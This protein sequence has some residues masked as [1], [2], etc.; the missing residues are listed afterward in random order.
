MPRKPKAVSRV[1]TFFGV[2][3]LEPTHLDF[4]KL[5]EQKNK[6]QAN[7]TIQWKDV[8]FGDQV[9]LIRE[10][11]TPKHSLIHPN[12]GYMKYWDIIIVCALVFTALVT[13][14][15]VAYLETKL[16]GLFVINRFIDVI[17]VKDMMMQFSLKVLVRKKHRSEWVKNRADIIKHYFKGW[18]LIDI[19][20]ILPFDIV[21]FV[22]DSP[23]VQRMKIVRVVR[24]LRLLKIARVLRASRIVK[25]WQ[26]HTGMSYSQ[27]GLI[28][29]AIMLCVVSHWMACLWGMLGLLMGTNLQCVGDEF[30]FK[31]DADGD[32]WITAHSWSADTP[33]KSLNVY[34]ASLHFAVMTITS[35][36]YGDI[37]PTRNMEYVIG[38][39]C[40]LAG[41]LTWAYV[42]GSI[43]GII[44]NANPIK[45]EF[46]NS[47]D[48]L[49]RML[50][51][52]HINVALRFELR[53]YLREQ[54]HHHYLERARDIT[55]TFSPQLQSRLLQETVM[56]EA[57]HK[58]WYFRPCHPLFVVK[59]SLLFN[60]MQ[61]A[62]GDRVGG[63][64][65]L[66]I[67]QRGTVAWNGHV[68]LP[69]DFWGADMIVTSELLQKDN[70]ALAMNFAEVLQ[71]SYKDLRELLDRWPEED[72]RIR[73][74]A[75]MLAFRTA[76]R[77]M[78]QTRSVTKSGNS[79]RG[80][81][82]EW[83][84]SNAGN[85]K[86]QEKMTVLNGLFEEAQEIKR[87]NA[88]MVYKKSATKELQQA[89][90]S[91]TAANCVDN[92]QVKVEQPVK[93]EDQDQ[94][95]QA[96]PHLADPACVN[97]DK[98]VLRVCEEPSSRMLTGGQRS[99]K[100]PWIQTLLANVEQ[101]MSEMASVKNDQ[102]LILQT[103]QRGTKGNGRGYD[104]LVEAAPSSNHCKPHCG[105]L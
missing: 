61:F 11:L 60:A 18:F 33:C 73:R 62:K 31:N 34:L 19:F 56:G 88:S 57:I 54:Q 97:F 96:D 72:I 84:K 86:H 32:S 90:K 52:Q 91:L 16:D 2:G 10:A 70:E 26:D 28:K 93:V 67:L 8:H 74:A 71:L 82:R 6:H 103:I 75:C 37:T 44:A 78:A 77:L 81:S 87:R 76:V 101:L 59:L 35:I 25:R 42:I 27:Q 39:L 7:T 5:A 47:M 24:I 55:Q 65:L 94:G 38:I 9:E 30:D 45:V 36:G 50:K 85:P 102:A 49:N 98:A 105:S 21:G 80:M 100:E 63:P 3:L 48:A 51:E 92:A 40:Q 23:A 79:P 17:F 69:G 43:C 68:L 12:C 22:V 4:S 15:E 1:K 41:G 29:F 99:P 89:M 13:P 66:C 14:Y 104:D 53:E 95:R 46:E 64:K 58:V 83:E 20:S